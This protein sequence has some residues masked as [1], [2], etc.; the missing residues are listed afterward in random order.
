MSPQNQILG[1]IPFLRYTAAFGFGIVMA[2]NM[3]HSAWVI[4]V[5][6]LFILILKIEPKLLS[7]SRTAQMLF[8]ILVLFTL[9]FTGAAIRNYHFNNQFRS[10][11][12]STKARFT[13]YV[14]EKSPAKNN[15]YKYLVQLNSQLD[16]NALVA[17]DEKI[18]LYNADSLTNAHIKPGNLI[19]FQTLLNPITNSNNPGE[20]NYQRY[21]KL[22]GIRYQTYLKRGI[23]ILPEERMTLKIKALQIQ[24]ILLDKYLKAGIEDD[25]FAVLA[26]LTLGNKNYLSNDLK[27]S[28]SASGAMH[29]LAVSGLHVGII[30]LIF[31]LL[32]R[33]LTK[34]QKLVVVKVLLILLFLW[35][36]AF[37]TGLSPSVLRSCTMFSFITIGE[38]LHRK[39]NIYSMLATSA[40][41]L[42]LFDPPIIYN[43]GFQLSYLAVISIVFFQPKIVALFKAENKIIK[44][45][46]DLTAVSIAAQIGTFAISIYYFHQFPVYFWL[47]NFAAIPAAAILLY[48]A[49][50]FFLATPVP[51]L[52]KII[53]VLINW[54]VK[55]LN[56]SILFIDELPFSVIRQISIDEITLALLIVFIVAFSWFIVN[57][58]YQPFFVSL[59]ILVIIAGYSTYKTIKTQQQEFIVFYNNYSNSLISLID[60]KN[61]YYYNSNPSDSITERSAFLLKSST[62]FFRTNDAV[63][64][65]SLLNG[66][67]NIRLHQQHLFFKNS[68]IAIIR[69]GSNI[70][71]LSA[72]IYWY[73]ERSNIVVNSNYIIRTLHKG[74]MKKTSISTENKSFNTLNNSAL[75]LQPIQ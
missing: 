19:V 27:S 44:W 37:I 30:Y 35:T 60:G 3:I 10:E 50:F 51:F 5:F 29:V 36:Y 28:F 9:I 48:L 38:N 49:T 43:V 57:Q 22:E 25:E 75:I 39:T 31:K 70:N 2:E 24:S 68:N 8:G 14:L 15:R 61:H 12:T 46:W 55:S 54:V 21:M 13:G 56:Y 53:G 16:S 66:E 62:E 32:L 67:T 20:F 1:K 26:A 47:S 63:P 33:P 6:F 4:P 17:I 34:F 42:M 64:L 74:K 11:I 52:A 18:V 71:D 73:P 23:T 58:K 59:F 7:N 40:F 41:F 69:D 72:N 65:I 45:L